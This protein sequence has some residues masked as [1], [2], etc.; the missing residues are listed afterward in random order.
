MAQVKEQG[1]GGEERKVPL[2]LS[3][4]SLFGSRFISHAVETENAL[5]RSFFALKPD[6][7][8][9]YPGYVFA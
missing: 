1:G 9:C 2:P 5:P 7:N 6:E 3:P 4:L 8:A